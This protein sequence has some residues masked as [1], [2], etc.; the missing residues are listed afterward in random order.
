MIEEPIIIR[1]IEPIYVEEDLPYCY[2]HDGRTVYIF[3]LHNGEPGER[4]I[5]HR[6]IYYLNNG[7]SHLAMAKPCPCCGG[8]NTDYIRSD[9]TPWYICYSCEIAFTPE[10]FYDLSECEE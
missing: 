2:E 6:K 4:E 7:K 5:Y 10:I 3:G 9:S 1:K 8:L